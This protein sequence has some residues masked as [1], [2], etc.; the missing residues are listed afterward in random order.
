MPR[1]QPTV[2]EA[3]K[4]LP[5]FIARVIF[6]G[7]PIDMDA[8]SPLMKNFFGVLKVLYPNGEKR[9][10]LTALLER[11]APDSDAHIESTLRAHFESLDS[12]KARI[13]C[14]T[15]EYDNDA[16]WGN[17]ADA[18]RGCVLGFKHIEA[19]STP[20]LAAK[21]VAYS[22][23]NPIVGSGLDFLIY[24]NTEELR[25]RT[26]EAVCYTKKISWSYEREWRALTWRS[27]EKEDA[28]FGDYSF[29]P[30]ELES[31]TLG[32]RTPKDVQDEIQALLVAQYPDTTLH[33]MKLLNGGL[34][35]KRLSTP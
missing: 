29:Y 5:E 19:L 2:A 23:E 9:K 4:L 13:L 6:D 7:A 10:E 26:Q 30:T 21:P 20:L 31:V 18:H 32:V 3:H 34:T 35:R 25:N 33:Q 14:V 22:A 17:Y 12:S 16:M 24:G 27:R 15:T 28:Q 1:F 8:L 11:D